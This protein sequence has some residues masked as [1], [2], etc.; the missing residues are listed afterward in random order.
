MFGEIPDGDP[1]LVQLKDMEI[2]DRQAGQ[3]K[4]AGEKNIDV[5]VWAPQ[6]GI[7]DAGRA[8]FAPLGPLVI[9]C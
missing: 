3:V 9:T 6:A 5:E 2:D 4:L 1:C 8:A 7:N